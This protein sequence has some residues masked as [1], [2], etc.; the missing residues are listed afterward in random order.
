[1]QKIIVSKVAANNLRKNQLSLTQ[2]ARAFSA[3]ANPFDKVKTQLGA[4]A[5]YN[6]P[7]LKDDRLG[8]FF[9]TSSSNWF[10]FR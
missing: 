9:L 10:Y 4:S 3:K 2:M 8:K 5:Y 7:A 6:L 1:M